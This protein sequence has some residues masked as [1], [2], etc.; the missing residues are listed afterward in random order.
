MALALLAASCSG[1]DG[2]VDVVDAPESVQVDASLGVV[3]L[4]PGE[5]I[6]LRSIIDAA[7][8]GGGDPAL[9]AVVHTALRVALE[10]FGGIQGF[11]VELGDPIAADCSPEGG[12][13]AAT[14]VL[15]QSDVVGVFAP[16]CTASL[17]T[18]LAPLDGVGMVVLS[19]TSTAPELT[20]SPFGEAGVNSSPAFH[21]TSPNMLAEAI[22][23]ASFASDEL[24]LQR[25]VTVEDGSA[26]TAG[27][28]AAF[29]SAF[30]SLGGTVVRSSVI[31][32]AADPTEELAAIA[33]TGPDLIFLPL[34][35]ERLLTLLEEWSA[36]PGSRGTVRIATSLARELEF[37]Q[38]PR[39]EDLYVT[40]PW[41]EFGDAQSAVTGMGAAQAIE[42]V[43]SLLGT[44]DVAGWWAHA[45]DAMTLLLR[46]IDDVSL[47]E[48]DG[49]LV[50]SRADLRRTL[51]A[52]GFTGMTGRVECDGFGDCGTRRSIIR[53]RE[54]GTVSGPDDLPTLYDTRD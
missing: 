14:R 8:D 26:R 5:R 28:A 21:R 24:G 34:G 11:R 22:A 16:S 4:A 36:T 41:L 3:R 49:T 6:Q 48:A 51:R 42:R 15:E 46:A 45:Y 37:L 32:P 39:S 10:D 27:M 13:A 18:A 17:I 50:I 30:E 20:Q 19:A 43:E 40:G 7:A 52:P 29:R 54:G 9:D 31:V 53:L 44:S 23:A 35:P 2:P 12:A 1:G 25:A 33:A 47:V 38:D